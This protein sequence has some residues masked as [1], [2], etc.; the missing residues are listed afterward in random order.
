MRS[1][2]TNEEMLE[3]IRRERPEQTI[4][5]VLSFKLNEHGFYDVW[6]DM[7]VKI[8]FSDIEESPMTTIKHAKFMLPYPM[9]KYKR[10]SRGDQFL[11]RMRS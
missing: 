1:P 3:Y 10:M 9:W 7:Q 8:N 5:E 4:H 2:E 11:Y 6:V